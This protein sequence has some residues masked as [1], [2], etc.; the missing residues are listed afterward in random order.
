MLHDEIQDTSIFES[1]TRIGE[2][3]L[4]LIVDLVD[5]K[6]GCL[7]EP[8]PGGYQTSVCHGLSG[9]PE[10]LTFRDDDIFIRYLVRTANILS[11]TELE[12]IP[13]IQSTIGS[14]YRRLEASEIS[15]I[16]PVLSTGGKGTHRLN[17][18][19]LLTERRSGAIVPGRRHPGTAYGL[20]STGD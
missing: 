15:L 20:R 1:D 12:E 11:L 5:A 19:I 13:Q 17:A 8:V 3:L 6:G 10:E 2:R 14:F 7:I 16:V 4:A 9:D 18:I